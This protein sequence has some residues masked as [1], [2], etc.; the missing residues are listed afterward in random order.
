MIEAFCSLQFSY[1]H[2]VCVCAP[3]LYL[4][5]SGDLYVL[6][7]DSAKLLDMAAMDSWVLGRKV[8]DDEFGTLDRQGAQGGLSEFSG[9]IVV[10]GKMMRV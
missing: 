8:L 2:F 10:V 4:Q 7:Y 3:R 6:I 1:D 9:F 5:K